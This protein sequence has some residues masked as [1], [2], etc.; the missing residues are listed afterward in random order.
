MRVAVTGASGFVGGAIAEHLEA[1][2]HDVLAFGRRPRGELRRALRKYEQWDI[3]DHVRRIDVEAVVHCAALVS[4]HASAAAFERAN[5]EGTRN[6]LQ[7]APPDAR[8]VYLS[9][10]SVYRHASDATPIPEGGEHESPR[11]P[12]ARSKRRGEQQALARGGT[13]FVLRPHIV[14]GPGDTTLWPRVI[15]AR[16]G[17]TLLVPGNG[18]NRV[19]VTHVG[20]LARAVALTLRTEAVPG[21]YNIADALAPSVRELLGTIFE[22]HA[23]P[24]TLRFVPR[25]L[26]LA[27]AICAELLSD[28]RSA[29]SRDE[30]EPTLTRFAVRG[31]ADSCVLDLT[32]ARSGL[33]YEP[34][35]SYLD[36]PL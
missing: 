22:R 5:V 15:E 25:S 17:E 31:L 4:A 8:F 11:S 30:H 34:R 10:A 21:I 19:S 1:E 23:L 13:A 6:V 33:H 3:T 2:G 12:Y 18:E 26:A 35:W 29:L 20:N 27:G 7:G 16:R 14:Y 24:T 32:R 28:A 36:G 9:T